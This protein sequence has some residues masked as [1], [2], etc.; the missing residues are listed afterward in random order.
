MLPL[1]TDI[2][3]SQAP[4]APYSKTQRAS[5]FL[6]KFVFEFTGQLIHI[7][8]FTERLNLLPG[9]IDVHTHVL[10]QFLQR[11]K[12]GGQFLFRK[13]ANLKIDVRA[14]FGLTRQSTLT[15]QNKNC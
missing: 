6:R 5:L 7:C 12:Y 14:P 1:E 11:L 10:A 3:L 8:R 15:D 4:T 2:S 9:G 13:H